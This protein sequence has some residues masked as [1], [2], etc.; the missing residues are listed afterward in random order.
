MNLT[1]LLRRLAGGTTLRGLLWRDEIQSRIAVA[2]TTLEDAIDK[3]DVRHWI[4]RHSLLFTCVLQAD[5]K[6]N[7]AELFKAQSKEARKEDARNFINAIQGSLHNDEDAIEVS[8]HLRDR[9]FIT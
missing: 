4:F 3:L 1:K 7:L 9:L 8:F 5:V 2:Y 6:A